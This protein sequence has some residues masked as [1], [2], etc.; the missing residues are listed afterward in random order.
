[1]SLS[2]Y[3]DL[4]LQITHPSQKKLATL[5]GGVYV[6]K[7]KDSQHFSRSIK[8]YPIFLINKVSIVVT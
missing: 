2:L 8:K 6:F 5:P 3:Y 4:S 7:E 1:M